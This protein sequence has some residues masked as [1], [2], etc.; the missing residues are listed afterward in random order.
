MNCNLKKPRMQIRL[1]KP[2]MQIRSLMSFLTAF[3]VATSAHAQVQVGDAPPDLLGKDRDGTVVH[4]STHHGKV[5]VLTFWATW[6]GYCL[7]ELPVLENLQR[8]VGKS[9]IEVVAIN[10]DK[11]RAHYVAMR[12]RLKDFQLTMTADERDGE[13]AKHYAVT[14]LPFI[15]M[16]NK[17]GRVAQVHVG[18]SE[19]S[20]GGF[21]DEINALLEDPEEAS[22]ATG[23]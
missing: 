22:A 18:Y 20:L 12:R 3:A 5:V 10:T 16:I 2:R 7:K 21:V 13:V 14:G 17:A 1:N 4:V 15:V 11:D 9:R 19:K 6:C 23:G 8:R